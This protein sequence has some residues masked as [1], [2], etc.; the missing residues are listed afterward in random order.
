ML[1][2]STAPGELKYSDVFD[3][4]H[5]GI[6]Q[7]ERLLRLDTPLGADVLIALRAQGWAKIGRDYRWTVDAASMRDDI[8]LLS[9]MH[10]PVTLWLQQTTSPSASS[11]YRPIHGFVHHIS[12]LGGDGGLA[13]YQIEFSSALYFLGHTRNDYYW[14]EKDA[15]QIVL[16]VFDRYP[17]LQGNIR[18]NI[19]TEPRIRSYCRQAESDLNFIHRILEDEGWYFYWEHAN[20]KAGA[21]TLVIVDRLTALPEVKELAYY[22]GNTDDEVDGLTQWAAVQALQS[23]RYTNRSFDYMRPRYDFEASSQLKATT[24]SN[25]VLATRARFRRRRWKCSSR[26]PTAIPVQTQA[27]TVQD[28]ARSRGTPKRAAIPVLAPHDGL[29]PARASI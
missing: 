8:A 17:Q 9:L 1:T 28:Y 20:D 11:S 24:L 10:Q 29:T 21:T 18:M 6:L 23:L 2:R 27:S 4:I 15:R 3:A 7:R 22:R 5:R 19:T 12:V 26:C 25:D 13:V 16:D 14:L